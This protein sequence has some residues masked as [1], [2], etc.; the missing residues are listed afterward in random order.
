MV[1]LLRAPTDCVQF[2]TGP[3]GN[4]ESFNFNSG[5]G[6]F[7]QNQQFNIC[8]RREEGSGQ[9]ISKNVFNTLNEI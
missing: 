3:A 6:Q 9:N 7:L 1:V 8:F 5:N 2:F 4:F